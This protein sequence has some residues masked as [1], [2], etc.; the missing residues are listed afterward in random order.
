MEFGWP[1]HH[2]DMVLEVVHAKK[3]M[4]RQKTCTL[5]ASPENVSY[6]INTQLLDTATA[7]AT[8]LA[9]L[10]AG[11]PTRLDYFI[12]LGRLLTIIHP[13]YCGLET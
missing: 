12:T 6:V 3:D 8:K 10:H 7:R 2:E 9:L 1:R 5:F 11:P 4:G 13:R